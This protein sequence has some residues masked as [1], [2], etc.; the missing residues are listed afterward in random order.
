MAPQDGCQT[1][2]RCATRT[3]TPLP[4]HYLGMEEA[5][6]RRVQSHVLLGGHLRQ[7]CDTRRCRDM[8]AEE[9]NDDR[10]AMCTTR[11]G[12]LGWHSHPVRE[13]ETET[14]SL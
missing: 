5:H 1:G 6:A 12:T 9:D 8:R 3:P 14:R 13:R 2:E 4:E 11:P 7:T 10:A